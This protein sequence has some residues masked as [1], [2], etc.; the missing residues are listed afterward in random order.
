MDPTEP[1]KQFL[2]WRQQGF[3]IRRV[4]HDRKFARPYYTAMRKAGFRVQDQ[5]QLYLQKSEGFRYIEHKAKIGCLYYLHADPFEYCVQNVRAAEK[6]DDAVQYEKIDPNS[7][8]DVFDAAVFATIRL[9]IETDRSSS[10]AGFFE[11][12]MSE[13]GRSAPNQWR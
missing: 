11:G 5:P 2:A 8:I 4:G 3:Q 9:L 1:V 7:R 10:A 12:T 13:T 6:V